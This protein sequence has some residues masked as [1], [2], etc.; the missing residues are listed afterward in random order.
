MKRAADRATGLSGGRPQ[1][2][3]WVLRRS[4]DVHA[5]RVQVLQRPGFRAAV[6]RAHGQVAVEADGHQRAGAVAGLVQLGAGRPLQPHVVGHRFGMFAGE[7][8]HFRALRVAQGLGPGGPA[9]D[10]GRSAREVALQRLVECVLPEGGVVFLQEGLEGDAARA[11]GFPVA[12]AEFLPEQGEH[13]L[14]GGGDVGVLHGVRVAQG[15]QALLEGAVRVQRLRG[16]AAQEFG[17]RRHVDEQRVEREPAGGAVG[18]GEVRPVHAQGV[19]GAQA[20]EGG[21]LRGRGGHEFRKIGEIAD[22]P[23]AFGAQRI[24][25]HAE[26]PPALTVAQRLGRPALRRR[27]DD[28]ALGSG[29]GARAGECRGGRVRIRIRI[30]RDEAVVAGPQVGRQPG[31]RATAFAHGGISLHFAGDEPPCGGS[32]PIHRGCLAFLDEDGRRQGGG[33][34]VRAH[35]GERALQHL[36]W[37][38]AVLAPEAGVVQ[39]DAGQA[40]AVVQVALADGIVGGIHAVTPYRVQRADQGAQ[41]APSCQR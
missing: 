5:A 8:L 19:Q 17:H 4:A 16:C 41:A 7:G 34:G 26:A 35:G 6:A 23:V 38:V 30:R 20:D 13:L 25:L 32:G 24:E 33:I 22:A 1:S 10:V 3:P 2:W 36:G 21:A 27:D 37:N 40:G 18:A 11:E 39:R 9:P 15:L 14:L 31:H 29:I 28:E 12:L